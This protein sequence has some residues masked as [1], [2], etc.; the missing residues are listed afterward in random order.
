[1]YILS[2]SYP[3]TVLSPYDPSVNRRE[4]N[5]WPVGVYILVRGR[6]MTKISIINKKTTL[7]SR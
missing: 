6:Q 3:C 2:I 4:E 7:C 1:M 5:P